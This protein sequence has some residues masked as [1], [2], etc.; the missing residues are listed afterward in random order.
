MSIHPEQLRY[1]INKELAELS[2]VL[3]TEGATELLM[4]T[5]ATETQCGR[6]LWQVTPGSTFT[7]H[8]YG[9]FQMEQAGYQDAISKILHYKPSFI[10]P[11]RVRLATDL[12]LAIWSARCYYLRFIEPIPHFKDIPG[13]ARYW[14][15]Y[16]NTPAGAGTPEKAEADYRAFAVIK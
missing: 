8:A 7:R 16:W 15:Q 4:L 5:A 13:L 11:P 6:W 2:P 14:K 1:L 10:V 3:A 9:I 12:R